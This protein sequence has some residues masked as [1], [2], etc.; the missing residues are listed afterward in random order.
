MGVLPWESSSSAS[1]NETLQ[2]TE[3][4]YKE[5]IEI[6]KN[7]LDEISW[8]PKIASYFESRV[9]HRSSGDTKLANIEQLLD[10]F[11]SARGRPIRRNASQIEWH[12]H[13][14]NALLPKIYGSDWERCQARVLKERGLKEIEPRLLIFAPRREG[15]TWNIAMLCAAVKLVCP[16]IEIT[17]FSVNQRISSKLMETTVQFISSIPGGAARIVKKTREDLYIAQRGLAGGFSTTSNLAQILQGDPNT[18]KLHSYPNNPDGSRHKILHNI[19]TCTMHIT[20]S[21]SS[22]V[23][24]NKTYVL[25]LHS[26]SLS[27]SLTQIQ[28]KGQT[29]R[30]HVTRRA[31]ERTTD[32]GTRRHSQR[33]LCKRRHCRPDITKNHPVIA[34]LWSFTSLLLS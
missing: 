20:T 12:K 27:L 4:W 29:R 16:G 3:D 15:K 17:I 14:I 10:S 6:E 18:S 2:W 5:E 21:S 23:W 1:S 24:R 11:K 25:L 7:F 9:Q 28:E 30:H 19:N 33:S 8:K 32:Q 13:C 22:K 34:S 31:R 26:L